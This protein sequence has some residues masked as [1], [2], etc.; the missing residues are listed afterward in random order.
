MNYFY[1]IW[2][3]TYSLKIIIYLLFILLSKYKFILG[4]LANI[5]YTILKYDEMQEI[6]NNVLH[7]SKPTKIYVL[8]IKLN[9]ASIPSFTD[10]YSLKW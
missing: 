7:Y 9:T 1:S 6:N 2:S 5:L 10:T 8:I 4:V 3:K